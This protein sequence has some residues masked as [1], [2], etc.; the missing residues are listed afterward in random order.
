MSK[1][2]LRVSSEW[3]KILDPQESDTFIVNITGT[4]IQFMYYKTAKTVL[5]TIKNHFTLGGTIGQ[6]RIPVSTYCYARACPLILADG[7]YKKG[8]VTEEDGGITIEPEGIVVTDTDPIDTVNTD[9]DTL[10]EQI[11][12]LTTSVMKLSNRVSKNKL[13]DIHHVVDYK[14][15]LR[16][17]LRAEQRNH[18]QFSFLQSQILD[19]RLGLFSAEDLIMELKESVGTLA[20]K[21][22]SSLEFDGD[23]EE[24]IESLQASINNVF[25]KVALVSKQLTTLTDNYEGTVQDVEALKKELASL[26][27]NFTSLNN[28]MVILASQYTV[29]AL[30]KAFNSISPTVA[31]DIKGPLNAIKNVL[32][33]LIDL[34]DRY[35]NNAVKKDEILILNGATELVDYL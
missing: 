35:E 1:L 7:T 18:Y 28:S 15:F 10:K 19:L 14:R 5:S 32:A 24:Y 9:L 6:A 29:E 27:T 30:D 33:R 17:F 26:H 12:Y 3:S 8:E 23:A 21:S 31:E 25:D 2:F 16:E 34:T 20:N 22:G 11:E 4:P 13:S